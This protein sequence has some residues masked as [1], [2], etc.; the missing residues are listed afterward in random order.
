MPW[1]LQKVLKLLFQG[2]RLDWNIELFIK[3]SENNV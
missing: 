3:Q 2:S 1:D